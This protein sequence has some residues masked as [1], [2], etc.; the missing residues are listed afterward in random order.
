M[1]RTIKVE[2]RMDDKVTL[3]GRCRYQSFGECMLYRDKHDMSRKLRTSGDRFS[4]VR[5]PACRRAEVT[6]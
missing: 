1:K 4:H 6:P 3:C 2:V 5:C